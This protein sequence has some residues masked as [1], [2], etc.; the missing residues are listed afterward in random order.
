M[1]VF[2]FSF[3]VALLRAGN[4][5]RVSPCLHPMRAGR[6]STSRL[7]SCDHHMFAQNCSTFSDLKCCGAAIIVLFHIFGGL[8]GSTWQ[9]NT[10]FRMQK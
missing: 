4:W 1:C 2:V 8:E 3:F 6:G 9:K 7:L 5:F 10:N